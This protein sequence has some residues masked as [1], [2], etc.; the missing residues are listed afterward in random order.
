MPALTTA[1]AI[2]GLGLAAGG[3][4]MQFQGASSAAHAQQQQLMLQQQE[5]A[6]RKQQME[7]DAMRRKRE[8][9][10]QS[11]AARAASL[12]AT[13]SQGAGGVNG[14]ALP[15]AYGGIAGQTG[16]NIQ[17]ADQNLEIGRNMFGLKSQETLSSMAYARAQ[18]RT[19]FGQGLS[20]LGQGLIKNMEPISRVGTYMTS[21]SSAALGL[22][23]YYGG[24]P[25]SNPNLNAS[26]YG[27]Y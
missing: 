4:A 17:G 7:L 18:A 2:A 14:S 15:G 1:I 8:M 19:G 26:T 10:R 13:T 21:S 24:S 5:E 22:G 9:V 16:V 3:A 12:T 25:S 27:N 20:S 11:I 23:G 6:Q